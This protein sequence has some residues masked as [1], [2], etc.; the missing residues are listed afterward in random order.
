MEY[1]VDTEITY[2]GTYLNGEKNGQGMEINGSG[3]I[4]FIG[5]YKNGKKWNGD[6]IKDGKEFMREGLNN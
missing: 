4:S 1:N 5:E 3:M 2:K 6:E